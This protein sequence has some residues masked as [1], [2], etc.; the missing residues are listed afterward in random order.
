[1]VEKGTILYKGEYERGWF[2]MGGETTE[3]LVVVWERVI[4]IYTLDSNVVLVHSA[5][6][7]TIVRSIYWILYESYVYVL[8]QDFVYICTQCDLCAH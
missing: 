4:G 6:A 7:H 1:M 8:E 5:H 2:G 3:A